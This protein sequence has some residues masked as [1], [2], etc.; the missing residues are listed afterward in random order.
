MSK[1]VCNNSSNPTTRERE[2]GKKREKKKESA[3]EG[4]AHS[5]TNGDK[6]RE[7]EGKVRRSSQ[8]LLQ[9]RVS[10]DYRARREVLG[11]PP[12]FGHRGERSHIFSSGDRTTQGEGLS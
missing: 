6:H 7:R 11:W 5:Q 9:K 12:S 2:R 1:A 3:E 8:L 4:K 10:A